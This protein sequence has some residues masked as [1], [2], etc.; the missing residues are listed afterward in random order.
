MVLENSKK[1]ERVNDLITI[2]AFIYK[3][4]ILYSLTFKNAINNGHSTEMSLEVRN[5]YLMNTCVKYTN[6]HVN[7]FYCIH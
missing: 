5:K 3:H 1:T 7:N 4:H 2:N 6:A